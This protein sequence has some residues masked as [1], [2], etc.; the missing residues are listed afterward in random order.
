MGEWLPRAVYTITIGPVGS[1]SD[2]AGCSVP[3]IKDAL[4]SLRSG[5]KKKEHA[6]RL[7][8]GYIS[9]RLRDRTKYGVN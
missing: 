8:A 1:E 5:P 7:Q 4:G 9:Y 2:T 3:I 6:H